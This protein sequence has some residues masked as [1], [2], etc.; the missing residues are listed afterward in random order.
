MNIS[1]LKNARQNIMFLFAIVAFCHVTQAQTPVKIADIKGDFCE[2]IRVS[3]FGKEGVIVYHGS[4][5]V[6][7]L[8]EEGTD[9]KFSKSGSAVPVLNAFSEKGWVLKL[10]YEETRGGDKYIIF[11]M[12]R[13]K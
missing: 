3:A 1:K 6:K 8:T 10:R 11:L 5:M 7:L 4:E 9:L 13:K 12:E 2:F